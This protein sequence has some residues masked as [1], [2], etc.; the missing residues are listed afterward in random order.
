V[1][2]TRCA[3]NRLLRHALLQWAFCSI[4]RS[5]WARAFYDQQRSRGKTHQ[6]AFRALA[7]RWLEIVHH[8]LS[9]R[10]CYDELVHQRNCPQAA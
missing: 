5:G 9:T 8:L 1:V 7:H 3:C 2:I 6:A 4:A 10:Q